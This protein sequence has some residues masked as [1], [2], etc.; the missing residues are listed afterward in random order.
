MIAHVLE[1]ADAIAGCD[2]VVVAVPDLAE[3]DPLADTVRALGHRVVRGPSADV[4][5]RY[6]RAADDTG[7]D[8][9]VRVT[10]DCPLLSPSVSSSVVAAFVAGGVDYASNTLERTFPRGLDTEVVSAHA[11]RVAAR[12]SREPSEREHVTPFVWQRP[13]RFAVRSLR[14]D[15]DHSHLRWTVDTP[16]DLALVRQVHAELGPGLFDT[17]AILELVLR[18]RPELSRLNA[19][20]VQKPADQ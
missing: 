3:D 15:A 2:E 14:G 4:L 11:L 1:R 9:V 13:E 8:V 20:V 16:L 18:R 5:A 10:A 17:D 19:D 12:E 6:V 7:A